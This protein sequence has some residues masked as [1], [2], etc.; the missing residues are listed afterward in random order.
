MSTNVTNGEAQAAATAEPVVVK[1]QQNQIFLKFS[2]KKDA[3]PKENSVL[4]SVRG[5]INSELRRK[6][7]EEAVSKLTDAQFRQ[8]TNGVTNSLKEFFEENGIAGFPSR[9]GY[10]AECAIISKNWRIISGDHPVQPEEG[11]SAEALTAYAT[12]SADWATASAWLDSSAKSRRSFGKKLVEVNETRE[13]R[14]V[15]EEVLETYRNEASNK[16]ADLL[17]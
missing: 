7:E 12:A 5:F 11:A 6:Q 4:A 3:A 1:I 10:Q 13:A 9:G 14:L 16:Y 2:D 17:N 8:F 15:F